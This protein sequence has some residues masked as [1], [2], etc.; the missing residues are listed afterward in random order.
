MVMMV[1]EHGDEAVHLLDLS[2]SAVQ[3]M[4]THDVTVLDPYRQAA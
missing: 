2:V 1:E 4:A 3:A